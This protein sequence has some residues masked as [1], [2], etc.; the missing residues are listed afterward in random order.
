MNWNGCRDE[1]V[2]AGVSSQLHQDRAHFNSAG[3][4]LAGAKVHFNGI[5]GVATSRGCIQTSLL[6]AGSSH[7]PQT[8]VTAN[9]TPRNSHCRI[10]GR[11]LQFVTRGGQISPQPNCDGGRS[12][13]QGLPGNAVSAWNTLKVCHEVSPEFS[14][15]GSNRVTAYNGREIPASDLSQNL[16]GR[17]TS[18]EGLR[19]Q[20]IVRVDSFL[21]L[22]QAFAIFDL[23]AIFP[24]T[25]S[26]TA[27]RSPPKC[28][29]HGRA[30]ARRL[31]S[32]QTFHSSRA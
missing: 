17:Q 9:S 26:N 31:G 1:V 23:R 22:C 6:A 8:N 2:G 4:M 30:F 11:H 15:P 16:S 27:A 25:P 14:N 7:Y 3:D 29:C 10:T 12:R 24:A 21:R 5:P 20:A 19:R 28:G 32:A 13:D 18:L